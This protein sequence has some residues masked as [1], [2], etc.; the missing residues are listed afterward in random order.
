MTM[1]FTR[2]VF[3]VLAA[4]LV[5]AAAHGNDARG[6][7]YQDGGKHIEDEAGEIHGHHR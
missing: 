1:D 2:F 6:G 4:I 7:V 3:Y 5:Y